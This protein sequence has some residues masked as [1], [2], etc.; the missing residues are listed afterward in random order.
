MVFSWYE[1]KS[2]AIILALFTIGTK[3]IRL[4]L[5]LPA[6]TSPNVLDFLIKQI[7]IE[8]ITTPEADSQ[9]ILG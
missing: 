3:D 9:A 1:Q 8:P 6:F 5:S 2:V 7:A 4:G